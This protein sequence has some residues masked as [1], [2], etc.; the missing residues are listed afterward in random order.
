[1]RIDFN[2]ETFPYGT[3]ES[4]II[5]GY[6]KHKSDFEKGMGFFKMTHV[7]NLNQYFFRS[8]KS[9]LI[10]SYEK[11]KLNV[12]ERN[13]LV[14]LLIII[15]VRVRFLIGIL[16]HSTPKI[17][18]K[19]LQKSLLGLEG[20]FYGITGIIYQGQD[21]SQRSAGTGRWTNAQAR[22]SIRKR[23]D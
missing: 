5:A 4:V 15:K 17:I 13:I 21:H 19:S 8:Q 16:G 10:S 14:K 9:K 18:P 12:Q 11:Q 3:Q 23:S 22:R 20:N 2:P 6:K 1:M 7:I